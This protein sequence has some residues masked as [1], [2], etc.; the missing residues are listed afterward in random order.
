MT[1]EESLLKS[2]N[3]PTVKLCAEIGVDK[4]NIIPS[5]SKVQI[6]VLKTTIYVPYATRI[7]TS[8]CSCGFG[9]YQLWDDQMYVHFCGL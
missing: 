9:N 4:V 8:Y 2:L 1:L 6:K 5:S 3:V 7:Y